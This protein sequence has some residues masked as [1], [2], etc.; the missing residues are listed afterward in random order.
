MM[1][2]SMPED[3]DMSTLVMAIPDQLGAD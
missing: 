2:H 1:H 3:E